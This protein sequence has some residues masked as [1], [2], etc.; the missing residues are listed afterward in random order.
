[1]CGGGQNRDERRQQA[2]VVLD[3]NFKSH[4]SRDD[5]NPFSR[6]IAFLRQCVRVV[7]TISFNGKPQASASLP[8]LCETQGAAENTGL[9]R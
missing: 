7:S 8:V 2:E 9:D 1:M 4:V 5:A 3:T 6:L